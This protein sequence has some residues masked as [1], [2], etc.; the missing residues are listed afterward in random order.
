MKL[1]IKQKLMVYV[2]LVIILVVTIV[3]VPAI[4]FF[5]NNLETM[6]ENEAVN[7][8]N[9]EKDLLDGL[10]NNAKGY[11]IS[12]AHYPGVSKAMEDRDTAALVQILKPLAENANID[13][14]TVADSNGVVIARTHDQ[15]TGDSVINQLNV[16]MALAGTIAS[17]VEPGTVVKLSARAGAPVK[18]SQGNI[19]GVI[20]AG[21]TV[22]KNELVDN[23]KQKYGVEST[24]FLG[25]E[26]INTTFIQDGKRAI[27]TKLDKAISD[28][29]L[30]QGQKYIGRADIFGKE[31]ITVY[32]PIMKADK[33]VGIIF[34]GLNTDKLMAEKKSLIVIIGLIALCALGIGMAGTFFMAKNITSPLIKLVGA[35]SK[36]AAGDLTHKVTVRSGDE[37]GTLAGSFNNMADQLRA[38][39]SQVSNLAETLAGSSEELTASAEQSAQAANQ[40]AGSITD[41]AKGADEQLAMVSGASTVVQQMSASIQQITASAGEIAGQSAQ[42]ANRANEGNNS[43][44]KA[45][46]QMASIEQTVTN[47][48]AVVT[49]L[50]ERSQKIGQIVDTIASIAG[51]TNLLALNAAIEAARAG[52]QG[53]GFAVVAEEVRKLAEQSEE[54]T[55]QIASLISEIQNDTEQAVVTMNEGTREVKLGTEVVN[56][57]GQ[58]FREIAALVTKVSGQMKEISAAIEQMANG[59]RQVVS[60]VTRIDGLSKQA[61]GEAQ[62][63]SAATEEQ[64]AAM[65]EIAANSQKLS[66]VAHTLQTIVARFRI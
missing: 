8:L 48:A 60:A 7:G 64:S 44:D 34:A 52:E 59:S 53:K 61:S 33:P 42:A 2:T 6:Y 37:I 15:K 35:V 39:I 3:T 30:K 10:K 18:N 29:V 62:T 22:S 45:A 16:K 46:S 40:I 27:G 57:S 65:E 41:V 4:Y 21:Y 36:I 24:I 28:I 55:K 32:E 58:A 12:F 66:Q 63:V 9:G 56:A 51:Q 1:S 11:A 47:S 25:D 23:I 19:I 50:S 5:S 17:T 43:A 20:T 31:Y 54:S 38:L 49:K 14:V 13:S 26:R